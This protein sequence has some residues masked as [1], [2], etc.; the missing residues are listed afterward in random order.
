[1][2][3]SLISMKLAY[4]THTKQYNDQ[5]YLVCVEHGFVVNKIHTS[6]KKT[7]H[8]KFDLKVQCDMQT[9]LMKIS[10]SMFT[11]AHVLGHILLSMCFVKS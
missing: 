7:M 9:L 4:Q 11:I 8:N 1:M 3:G 10:I 5:S 2:I 6:I